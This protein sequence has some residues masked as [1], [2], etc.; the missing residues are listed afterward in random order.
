MIRPDWNF[1]Y[2]FIYFF[3]VFN[4]EFKR[5]VFITFKR[6]LLF[7][8]FRSLIFL[9][10]FYRFP[11]NILCWRAGAFM[12]CAC[13]SI[14]NLGSL[15]WNRVYVP[16]CF[17]QSLVVLIKFIRHQCFIFIFLLWFFFNNF[18]LRMYRV[19]FFSFSKFLFYAYLYCK[20]RT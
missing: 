13:F 3:F 11:F 17:Y 7:Y 20:S 5:I 1:L 4:F 6:K 14:N 9:F 8:R 15:F 10:R 16:R 18:S 12:Q 19:I 2:L